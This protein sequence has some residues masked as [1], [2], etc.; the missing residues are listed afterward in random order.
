[1]AIADTRKSGFWIT[2]TYCYYSSPW[3]GLRIGV[4]VAV[5]PNLCLFCSRTNISRWTTKVV[6][7]WICL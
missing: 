6:V 7:F 3:M 2:S 4:G 1:M 5:G